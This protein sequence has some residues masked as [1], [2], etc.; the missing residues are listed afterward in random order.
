[1]KMLLSLFF[2]ALTFVSVFLLDGMLISWVVS[3]LH[4]DARVI[5]MIG[6][7]VISLGF[8]AWVG[9]ALGIFVAGL[10]YG[11]IKGKND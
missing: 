4:G 6:L 1:M 2:G 11:L 7:W 10:I 3:P 8:A 9:A 5:V